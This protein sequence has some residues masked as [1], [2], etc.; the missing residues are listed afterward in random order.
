[1]RL[2]SL[3]P[4]ANPLPS[5]DWEQ[6]ILVENCAKTVCPGGGVVL[7]KKMETFIKRRSKGCWAGRSNRCPLIIITHTYIALT[8]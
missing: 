5:G 1:M 3:G 7:Q 2:A 8:V 4:C 6:F